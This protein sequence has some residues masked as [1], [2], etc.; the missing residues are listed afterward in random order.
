MKKS[1]SFIGTLIISV[2]FLFSIS[3][4]GFSQ[5]IRILPL[6]NSIT[7]DYNTLDDNPGTIRSNSVRLSYRYR[8]YQLLNAS[9]YTWDFVGN[10]E[11][12]SPSLPYSPID[13]MDF[14]DNAGYPGITPEELITVLSTGRDPRDNTCLIE[15]YLGGCNGSFLAA[16]KPDVILLHIG[17]NNLNSNAD[18]V[19]HRDAVVSILNLVD[20]YESSS[21]KTVVVF[22]AMIV[23]RESASGNP[24][25]SFT[26][27]YNSLLV[28]LIASRPT[29]K[30]VIVNMETDAG[31]NYRNTVNGGDMFDTWHPAPSGYVKMAEKWYSVM[32]N[33]NL[34]APVV[35]NIPNQSFT[36][37]EGSKTLNLDPYVFDPQDWDDD[38]TWSVTGAP[39]YFNLA[40]SNGTLTITPKNS[41]ISAS[42]TITLGA[43]DGSQG[44]NPLFDTDALTISYTA[45]N[46]KPVITGVV[47]GLTTPYNTSISLSL[48]HLTVA[49]P[50]NT[51]PQ[52]FTLTI[53]PG[54]NYAISENTV[55]PASG[56][57]GTLH[58]SVKV[59][60][61][62]E[63]SDPTEIDITVEAQQSSVSDHVNDGLF[64]LYPNPASNQL[65][66][67]F[68]V[69]HDYTIELV[70]IIGNTW[71]SEEHHQTGLKTLNLDS[72]PPGL[73]FLRIGSSEGAHSEKIIIQR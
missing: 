49:D 12:G 26:T 34:K 7:W 66:I 55:I 42:E 15:S 60:D 8:L 4:T 51:Y 21:G 24:E 10:E 65:N 58:V 64:V 14:S 45:I 62:H 22:L 37:N 17:T 3:S 68:Q 50:D 52:D 43:T 40:F 18:A 36:E 19:S 1:Y 31:I 63:F 48:S 47:S 46:D 72:L 54:T 61:G 32:E 69:I 39:Q 73:Y 56:F 30:L 59:N 70:D 20:Q 23:N 33:Y 13:S 44:N 57:S 29:D 28:N 41:E 38:I 27:Y 16:Y 9:G 11:C 6:G 71:I 53:N 25:H 5:K 67:D 2:V 35:G